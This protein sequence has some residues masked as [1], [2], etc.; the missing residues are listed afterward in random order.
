MATEMIL[1]LSTISVT[2]ELLKPPMVQALYCGLVQLCDFQQRVFQTVPLYLTENRDHF[3]TAASLGTLLYI[4]DKMVPSATYNRIRYAIDVLD[5]YH[6]VM[7][8][9]TQ[10]LNRIFT[11]AKDHIFYSNAFTTSIVVT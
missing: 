2:S 7:N 3:F 5:M 11:A 4:F 6:E 1:K 10:G 9:L 8:D